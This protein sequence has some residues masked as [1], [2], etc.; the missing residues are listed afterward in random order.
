MVLR[1]AV[2]SVGKRD[3][4]LDVEGCP[5]PADVLERS[6]TAR[7]LHKMTEGARRAA[8]SVSQSEDAKPLDTFTILTT[9]PNALMWPIHN[10]ICR[11]SCTRAITRNAPGTFAFERPIGA[12]NMHPISHGGDAEQEG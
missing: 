3:P 9:E 7:T 2:T 12:V 5:A 11:S 4:T 8:P 1:K 6:P 10:R